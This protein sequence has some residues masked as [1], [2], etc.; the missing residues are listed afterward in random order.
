MSTF[1]VRLNE[2]A[3]SN[4]QSGQNRG[5]ANRLSQGALDTAIA[6]SSTHGYF[7]SLQRQM[8]AMGPNKTSRKLHDGDTF[9]DV[10][11]WKRFTFPTL[12]FDQAFVFVLSDDGSVWNDFGPNSFAVGY[13]LMIADNTQGENSLGAGFSANNFVDVLGGNGNAASFAMIQVGSGPTNVLVY[14]N[15]LSTFISLA[16]STTTIFDN[17]DLPITSIAIDNRQAGHAPVNI[18][19]LLSIL[20]VAKS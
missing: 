15:G 19:I 1:Q 3:G 9:V 11:Y 10:N 16:A 13:N 6:L 17:G 20:S 7:P 5:G 12:P 14:F 2:G 8:Y 4:P 18:N